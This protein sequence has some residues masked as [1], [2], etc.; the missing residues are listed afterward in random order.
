[1][2]PILTLPT[3]TFLEG[4]DGL[5]QSGYRLSVTT[6]ADLRE[7]SGH[8]EK[9]AGLLQGQVLLAYRHPC[10]GVVPEGKRVSQSCH[11]LFL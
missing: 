3:C 2:T 9:D 6:G 4:R 10:E 1:M 7:E 5:L 8:V 11:Y